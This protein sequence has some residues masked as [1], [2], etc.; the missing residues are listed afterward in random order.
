MVMNILTEVSTCLIF[1]LLLGPINDI[2]KV[3]KNMFQMLGIVNDSG[4]TMV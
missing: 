1:S 3:F 2:Q 4:L